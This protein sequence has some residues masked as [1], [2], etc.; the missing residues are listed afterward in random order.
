M[1]KEGEEEG[2]GAATIEAVEIKNVLDNQLAIEKP[3]AVLAGTALYEEEEAFLSR[4]EVNGRSLDEF[5]EASY[6][7][8][9]S[10]ASI[11]HQWKYWLI[12]VCYTSELNMIVVWE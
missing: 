6:Q 10:F 8:H 11:R 1:N 5:L 9:A 4:Q 2:K 7:E 12:M 3:Q